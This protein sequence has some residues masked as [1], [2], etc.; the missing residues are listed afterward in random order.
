MKPEAQKI[1]VG[2]GHL[3]FAPNDAN[4][5]PQGER[6]IGDTPGFQLTANTENVQVYSS[7]G[8]IAELLEDVTTQVTREGSVTVQHGSIENMAIWLIATAGTH[9]QT[10]DTVTDETIDSIEPG[11]WYQIGETADDYRG[12]RNV[13][14]VVVNKTPSGTPEELTLGTDYDLE[15]GTARIYIRP[16]S[17]NVSEGDEVGWDYETQEES[18]ETAVTHETGPVRGK[19]RYVAANSR[20]P[21]RDVLVPSAEMSPTGSLALKSRTEA[22]QMEYNLRAGKRGSMAQVYVDGRPA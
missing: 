21:N 12:V 14:N 2:A 1:I 19:L 11:V 20:G 4:G 10:A 5:E 16:D 7:D 13:T 9:D 6:Y 18:W 22:V 3:Y 8:P 15:A 17:P